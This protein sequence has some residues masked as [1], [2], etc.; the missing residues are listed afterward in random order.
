MASGLGMPVGIKNPTSGDVQEAVDAVVASAAP[1]HHVGLSKEVKLA[2]L[3]LPAEGRT[4]E[5][6]EQADGGQPARAC[7]PAG[8]K[9]G[10]ELQLDD[11]C[12]CC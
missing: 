5:G 10:D 6:R 2:V 11:G 12:C 1:H 4:G 3:V 8:R 7:D 9:A